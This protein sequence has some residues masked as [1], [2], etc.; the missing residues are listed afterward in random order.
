MGTEVGRWERG[1]ASGPDPP[2]EVK[3]RFCMEGWRRIRLY[4][5]TAIAI[6]LDAKPQERVQR[7]QRYNL[8][9]MIST[10]SKT[11]Q[12]AAQSS[13]EAE[14]TV[15]AYDLSRQ[16]QCGMLG[17]TTWSYEENKARGHTISTCS[18]TTSRRSST[19]SQHKV[20]TDDNQA[21][22]LIKYLETAKIRK[23]MLQM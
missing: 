2:K 17:Y 20:G 13:A 16:Q 10:S 21:G 3:E 11:Q 14:D 15:E 22:L 12:T 19:T 1:C 5:L 7:V 23:H 6:G 9:A 18:A 8:Q 4:E